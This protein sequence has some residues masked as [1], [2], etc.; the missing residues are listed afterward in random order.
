M[1]GRIEYYGC[2]LYAADYSYHCSCS[3]NFW[4]GLSIPLQFKNVPEAKRRKSGK[5]KN[6]DLEQVF[7]SVYSYLEN[8]DEE[9][10]TLSHLGGKNEGI[11]DKYRFSTIWKVVPQRKIERTVWRS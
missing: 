5:P 9:Q 6:K 11:S 4:S 7:I 2:D 1:R 8:N 3:G 10:L